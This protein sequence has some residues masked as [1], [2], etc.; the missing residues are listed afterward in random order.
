M[1]TESTV[2]N[3]KIKFFTDI[4]MRDMERYGLLG[5]P[6][7]DARKIGKKVEHAVAKE[8]DKK[9][10]IRDVSVR[11]PFGGKNSA[12]NKAKRALGL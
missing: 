12:V 3:K 5:G 9:L 2:L 7:S 11:T 8:F 10:G 4:S 1:K 6:N